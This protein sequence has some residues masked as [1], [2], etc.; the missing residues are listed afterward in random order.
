MLIS[1][2]LPGLSVTCLSVVCSADPEWKCCQLLMGCFDPINRVYF[3]RMPAET[4]AVM[5]LG[6]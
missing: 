3:S 1:R 4:R 2:N 6:Q 5:V